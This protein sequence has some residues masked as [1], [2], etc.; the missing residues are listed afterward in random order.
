MVIIETKECMIVQSEPLASGTGGST[1]HLGN[2]RQRKARHGTS[3]EKHSPPRLIV[4][5][6]L[7]DALLLVQ[8]LYSVE[9]RQRLLSIL[10][11]VSVAAR[12]RCCAI[13]HCLSA[14][15]RYRD[16]FSIYR[17]D[18]LPELNLVQRHQLR[19][20][21]FFAALLTNYIF[22]VLTAWVVGAIVEHELGELT[23]IP[24]TLGGLF[25][26][27]SFHSQVSVITG[28]TE[29]VSWF[30]LAL[31]FLFYLRQQA[32]SVFIILALAIL[33]RETILIVFASIS[34]IAL[35]LQQDKQ[36]FNAIIFLWSAACC[37]AYLLMRTIILP[38]PGAT[39]QTDPAAILEHLRTFHLTRDILFQGFL[40]QNLLWL[41]LIAVILF[42]D[43]RSR[44]LWLPTLLG[45][46][47]VLTVVSIAAGIDNNLGR[48]ASILSPIWAAFVAT[49]CVRLERMTA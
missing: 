2:I 47:L 35:L 12:L 6:Q 5:R 7:R 37:I 1:F 22:L 13:S 18:L 32:L 8:V 17:R 24:A 11:Y 30:L 16:P 21:R 15:Q 36:R 27:L 19:S 9:R 26:L 10:W 45:T 14:T 43:E 20:A 31:A 28:L 44:R 39:E 38:I 42:G 4:R 49:F 29:G 3:D 41:Y 23:F 40:S 46:F 25:C 34:G 33:Q 48:I